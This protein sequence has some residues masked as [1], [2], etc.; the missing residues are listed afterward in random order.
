MDGGKDPLT[1]AFS[2]KDVPQFRDEEVYQRLTGISEEE[3]RKHGF[4]MLGNLKKAELA[5]VQAG[6]DQKAIAEG[7]GPN[8]KAKLTPEEFNELMAETWKFNNDG[9]SETGPSYDQLLITTASIG[10][11]EEERTQ[12]PLAGDLFVA[13]VDARRIRQPEFAG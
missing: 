12:Q 10:L 7:G 1:D 5:A 4:T 2:E 13:D 11:S 8:K 9:I 3:L 6:G